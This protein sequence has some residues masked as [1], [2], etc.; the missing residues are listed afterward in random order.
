MSFEH[1]INGVLENLLIEAE[2]NWDEGIL[3]KAQLDNYMDTN[4]AQIVDL[5]P[6]GSPHDFEA[7]GRI[8]M[9][10]ILDEIDCIVAFDPV[11]KNP[12][13]RA[14]RKA[15]TLEEIINAMQP[16]IKKIAKEY[17]GHRAAYDIDDAMQEGRMAV[18][19]A[20]KNDRG[21]AWFN[22]HAKIWIR[23]AISRKSASTHPFGFG[24]REKK[25]TD[26]GIVSADALIGDTGSSIADNIPQ[27]YTPSDIRGNAPVSGSGRESSEPLDDLARDENVAQMRHM[28]NDVIETMTNVQGGQ[29]LKEI[30]K[31]SYGLAKPDDLSAETA[32]KVKELGIDISQSVPLG[33]IAQIYGVTR[34]RINTLL[35]K[36]LEKIRAEITGNDQYA[37]K[38]K[39]MLEWIEVTGFAL[40]ND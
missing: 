28:F 24:S 18:I 12:S 6:P 3:K 2:V 9:P 38:S 29:R 4:E 13:Q 8:K 23:S 26:T 5:N 19:K 11:T 40:L 35:N 7:L 21:L 15:W 25:W 27:N 17:S 31:M 33:Q 16:T 39:N 34:Q 10:M 14:A 1:C 30:I 37:Q 22:H 20:L 32:E 36:A